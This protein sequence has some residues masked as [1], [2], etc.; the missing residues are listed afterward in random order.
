MN[1]SSNSSSGQNYRYVVLYLTPDKI[2]NQS[3]LLQLQW[4]NLKTLIPCLIE[5][6]YSGEVKVKMHDLDKIFTGIIKLENI[7]HNNILGRTASLWFYLTRIFHQSMGPRVGNFAEELL[8]YWINNSG[9][10]SVIGRNISLAEALRKIANVYIQ[11]RNKIDFV[12]KS[13]ERIAFIEIRTSEHT[14]GRTAQESLL[15]KIVLI[16]YFL[17]DSKV[18]LREKLESIGIREVD[19][20]IAIL[21]NE[22]HE[23]L[24][25]ENASVGRFT[26]LVNYIMEDRHVWGALELGVNA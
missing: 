18:K 19:L 10:Y 12:L 9:N 16:L 25:K 22:N 24:T 7:A 8:T 15:D 26:S 13:K 3:K 4:N 20:S 14:G 17:E 6:L 11:G 23:L 1:P 5:S 2:I 21:F